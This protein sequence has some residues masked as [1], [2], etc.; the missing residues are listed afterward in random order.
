MSANAPATVR[1]DLD[2]AEKSSAHK[3]HIHT[4]PVT[5]ACATAKGHYDPTLK[6]V[7]PYT[8]TPG[9][10]SSYYVGDISGKF[11]AISMGTPTEHTD[12]TIGD[13]SKMILGRSIVIHAKDGGAPR[14]ACASIGTTYVA[15][16]NGETIDGQVAFSQTSPGLPVM[17]RT[18]LSGPT[19]TKQHAMH[20]HTNALQGD[21]ASAKGHYDPEGVETDL[22]YNPVPGDLSSYYR[23]AISD[24]FQFIDLDTVYA[25]Q[26]PTI[27]N[28][29]DVLGLSV[30]VHAENKGSARVGCA[31]VGSTV[32]AQF[33]STGA[34]TGTITFAQALSGEGPTKVVVDISGDKMTNDHK[35]HIHTDAVSGGCATA[36]GHYDPLVV[37]VE[38]YACDASKPELC[39]KGDL[40]GKHGTVNLGDQETYFDSTFTVD[41]IIGR[42][43]VVHAAN[44]GAPRVGCASI[45]KTVV[46]VLPYGQ[47]I[48]GSIAFAQSSFTSPTKV[49][50][51]VSPG[52][53]K[54]ATA[55]HK[56][57]LHSHAVVGDAC[58][59]ALGHFDPRGVETSSYSPTPGDDASYYIGDLSGYF[60]LLNV[61]TNEAS[62]DHSST[63]IPLW[64]EE[65]IVGRSLVFHAANSGAPRVACTNVGN[66]AV[67][68]FPYSADGV[69]GGDITF[70][71]TSPGHPTTVRVDL[72]GTTAGHKYHIHEYAKTGFLEDCQS[73]GGHFDPQRV[74]VN[75]YTC[76]T[77]KKTDC[78]VGDLSGKEGALDLGKPVTF[79]DES[80][81][82]YDILGL[83]I[84]VHAANGDKPR[85]ACA[86]IGEVVVGTFP[87]LSTLSGTVKFSSSA[88]MPTRVNYDISADTPSSGH[89]I[90]IHK[91]AVT[92][93]CGTAGGHWDPF[94][95]EING[96]TCDPK[97]SEK[98]YVGHLDAKHAP[99]AVPST[100]EY[101]DNEV[102]VMGNEGVLGRSIVVHAANGGAPRIAC[103]TLGSSATTE[104][105]G[106]LQGSVVFSQNAAGD[107]TQVR[108]DVK[109]PEGTSPS[110]GH[111]WH[112]HVNKVEE[113]NVDCGQAGVT[114]TLQAWRS[115]AIRAIPRNPS[116]ATKAISPANLSP[117]PT[118]PAWFTM[119][120]PSI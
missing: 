88:G 17:I 86:S 98:C 45:G 26:D 39:Y 50:I 34:V 7:T 105:S 84:V 13:I 102:R 112:I 120:G 64:G 20:L 47:D 54:S 92:G 110:T 90:H 63:N 27:P 73:T 42:S 69:T 118:R 106:P 35:Y 97:E 48:S 79:E 6:E 66:V 109:P 1:I 44:R 41:E 94:G 101:W 82:L 76:D 52:V 21:C 58:A 83:G 32:V 2:N 70:A 68:T 19:A 117:C 25:N 104:L 28:V 61:P 24:K 95:F 60:G 51:N 18:E 16:F 80:I 55:S 53:G 4:H 30:V 3:M 119:T 49:R 14:I 116:C 107:A 114:L 37:E 85:I 96:Y 31:S 81:Q 108:V 89:K 113:G 46:A 10:L 67:A 8:P 15:L 74:E 65:S 100:V 87:A 111:K 59:S 43:I 99:L 23:G 75:G 57:H 78:Y 33:P 11:G 9:D 29:R 115:T 40:S 36:A 22:P 12:T 38:G 93:N 103:L 71:Q 91:E 5:G 77:N 62:Y 56:F 72:K